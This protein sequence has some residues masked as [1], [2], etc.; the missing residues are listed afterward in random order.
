MELE[1]KLSVFTPGFVFWAVL[2]VTFLCL[3]PLRYVPEELR[4]H[5]SLGWVSQGDWLSDGTAA[6]SPHG[7]ALHTEWE[8]FHIIFLMKEPMEF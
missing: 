1:F 4:C 7:R 3:N 6:C 2:S 8:H 5:C